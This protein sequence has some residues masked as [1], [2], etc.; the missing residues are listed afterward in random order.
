MILKDLE[1]VD[2]QLKKEPE[3][4]NISPVVMSQSSPTGK[5]QL[6]AQ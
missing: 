1:T 2:K 4:Q 3:E 5:F 6:T